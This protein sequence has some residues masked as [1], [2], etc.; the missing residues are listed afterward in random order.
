[1]GVGLAEIADANSE[2]RVDNQSVF[3]RLRN[4]ISDFFDQMLIEADPSNPPV[5]SRKA[6]PSATDQNWS[7][8]QPDRPIK[9]A[10]ED[11]FGRRS[12][13]DRAA[14]VLAHRS[15]SSSLIVGVFG[16]WGDGKTSTLVMMKERL[17]RDPSVILV[18]YN[19]WFF[20]GSTEALTRSF[21]DTLAVSLEKTRLFSRERIGRA[22]ERYAE[23]VPKVGKPLAAFGKVLATEH[24]EKARDRIGEVLR[25]NGKRVIIFIDD[26][27]RLDRK[28]IQTLFKLVRLSG[29]FPYTSYVL[30]FDDEVVAEALG[31]A[32]GGHAKA[33]ARFLEKIIQVPLHLP[34]ANQLTLRQ[35]AFTS[36]DRALHENQI[37]L[38]SGEA[39]ELGNAFAMGFGPVLRTPRQ[40]KLF[41]NAI[42]FA[43]PILK[44]EVNVVDQILIEGIRIF[45]PKLYSMMRDQSA[46][47][48]RNIGTRN[49]EERS[50]RDA[51]IRATLEAAGAGPDEIDS[52]RSYL[53]E[54]LF[55][56]IGR[57]E[58][59]G[60]W[61]KE[62]ASEKRAC[63]SGYF[64][65]YFSY[66]VPSQDIADQSVDNLIAA[67]ADTD[68]A[69]FAQ[70]LLSLEAAGSFPLLLTKLRQ[71]Q[72]RVPKESISGLISALVLIA[73][74]LPDTR[75][76]LG[77]S[78]LE[79][80]AL[81]IA[82]LVE[83]VDSKERKGLVTIVATGIEDPAVAFQTLRWMLRDETEEKKRGFLTEEEHTK[84]VDDVVRRWVQTYG[85]NVKA[86]LPQSGAA[87]FLG[88]TAEYASTRQKNAV[89]KALT[90]FLKHDP[91]APMRLIRAYTPTSTN[92]ATGVR[93][94]SDFRADAYETLSKTLDADE[95]YRRLVRQYGKELET[96]EY[97][98]SFDDAN[99]DAVDE[100]L[101][102]QFAFV[103]R[104]AKEK[105]NGAPTD[106]KDD[107]TEQ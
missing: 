79:E 35:L 60:D 88:Y 37:Q 107:R 12:F 57:S 24:L 31:E 62:W 75:A 11:L 64:E 55:P 43:I 83:R 20:E 30:A 76:G 19:P 92:L 33:G 63:S 95:L 36:C 105:A 52:I 99:E 51:R 50:G 100:R 81:L 91:E 46:L 67:A 48:L 73:N 15:D 90:D 104:L 47:F 6:A 14:K 53:L 98:H 1:M 22:L 40:V 54:K 5:K 78:P 26:I 25:R 41:D 21:F 8:M 94:L 89:K 85:K 101:A 84:A 16:P 86:G 18:D 29:D 66:G 72:D 74:K 28:E 80:A 7:E 106:A 68:P 87:M 70:S 45:Y 32:Y 58:Y 65:R 10:K 44:G 3:R 9:S 56:R 61:E 39:S 34:R 27:D 13:A 82:R 69:Q 17:R 102:N 23:A 93:T 38:A 2:D 42:T 77:F 4:S 49:D 97:R 96:S 59:G 103:H 71:R